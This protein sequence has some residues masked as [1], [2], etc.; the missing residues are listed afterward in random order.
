MPTA[1]TTP[2]S[3]T[4]V[5]TTAAPSLSD[6]AARAKT[7]RNRAVDLY[8]VVAMAAVAIG[9]WIAMAIS[10]NADGSL[11]GGNALSADPSLS[12]ISWILQVMPLFFVVG[13]FSSA[14]SLDAHAASGSRDDGRSDRPQDWIYARLR[15]MV[16]PTAVL[17]ASWIILIAGGY[18][19]GMGAIVAAGATA[20]AIPLWFLSNYTIDTAIAPSVLPA[21]RRNPALVA[22]GGIALYLTLEALRILDVAGLHHLSYLNW[23]LGWLLFQVAGFAWRDRMLPTGRRMLGLAG[24]FW[25]AAIAAVTV[26][27]YPVSMVHFD[28]IA[29]SPTHP[30]SLAL[31][32]FGAAYSATAI[33]AAP[34]VSRFL[35]GNARVWAGVVGANAVAMSVYLWHMTAAVAASALLYAVGMLPSAEIGSAAWW[36]QKLPIVGLAVVFLGFIVSVVARIEQKALLAP[37]K[38]WNGSLVSMMV[39]AAVLSAGIKLW[40]SGSVV[41]VIGGTLITAVLAFGPTRLSSAQLRSSAER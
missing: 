22:G 2:P 8:R 21:F 20:A 37:R 31:M 11:E 33:A 10:V 24:A 38:T 4:P 25:A 19:T 28:G 16:T 30:P 14:M 6:L 39:T 13:G 34:A 40:A 3:T 9:H 32:L 5:A 41:T 1:T 35:A 7:D 18:L 12:W 15:R 27:P 36:I 17:A 23:V 26:G 29:N